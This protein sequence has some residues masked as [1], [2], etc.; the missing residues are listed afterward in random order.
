MSGEALVFWV[1]G[2]TC[3]LGALGLV[4]SH[5]AV[6]SA[7]W[8]ALTMVG[9]AV[10]YIALDAPFLG[11]VQVIVYTGAVMMLFLFVIMLVGVDASDSLVETIR[12]QRPAAILACSGLVVLLIAV[13]GRATLPAAP[14]G[15]GILPDG[16]ANVEG[17]ASLLFSD[18]L[19]AFEVTAALLIT[20][21]LGALVLTHREQANK[22]TQRELAERRF[23]PPDGDFSGAAG[24][25]APGVYAR[26]NAV[27][28]PALLPDGTPAAASV[29]RVLAAREAVRSAPGTAEDLS[30]A[31]AAVIPTH[32]GRDEVPAEGD[33]GSAE[34][35]RAAVGEPPV[36]D[37]GTGVAG[38]GEDA[39]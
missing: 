26:H 22:P 10:L 9:L 21:A 15:E 39:R 36:R 34:E 1:V 29:S 2:P 30:R 38:D 25:P 3:V 8:L 6:H 13:L 16:Q 37:E 35:Q 32:A 11:V 4:L 19:L 5:K 23:T 12:G 7:L 17:I 24:L 31:G 14:P 28:T 18:Y 20:A 33:P 27:D